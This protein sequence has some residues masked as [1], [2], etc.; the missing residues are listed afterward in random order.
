MKKIQLHK[1]FPEHNEI[2]LEINNKKIKR[3]I[4]KYLET[5]YTFK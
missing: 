3:K 1:A 2:R 5:K 4:S